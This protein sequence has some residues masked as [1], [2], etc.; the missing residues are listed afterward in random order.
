MGPPMTAI[1]G[2][3][4]TCKQMTVD[5]C[6]VLSGLPPPRGDSRLSRTADLARIRSPVA[7]AVSGDVAVTGSAHHS[8]LRVTRSTAIQ[9]AFQEFFEL[10]SSV[11]YTLGRVEPR[12]CNAR[13]QARRDG[14]GLLGYRRKV[15]SQRCCDHKEPLS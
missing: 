7:Y 8:A 1:E 2:V 10:L 5:R 12:G 11:L 14:G 9:R 4:A 6:A 15:A 13:S 3:L